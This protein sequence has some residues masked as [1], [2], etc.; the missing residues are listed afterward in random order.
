MDKNQYDKGNNPLAAT[1]AR[2]VVTSFPRSKSILAML[3]YTQY[4]IN[5]VS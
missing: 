1:A 4:F 3:I 2:G 5:Q